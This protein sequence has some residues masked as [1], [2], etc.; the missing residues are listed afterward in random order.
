MRVAAARVSDDESAATA[1]VVRSPRSLRTLPEQIADQ[2]YAGIVAGQ[3]QPG[4]RIREET[5][6]TDLGVSRGPVREAIRILERDAVVRV[7]PNKGAHVTKL[8]AKELNDI[9]EIRIVLAGAMIRRL[10]DASPAVIASLGEK[11]AALERLA[12]RTGKVTEYAS[13]SVDLIL[14]MAQAAGNVQ[15]AEILRSLARQSSR[16][17]QIV[18]SEPARRKLSARKWR[19]LFEALS[20]GRAEEAGRVMEQ[21][22][23]ELRIEAVRRLSDEHASA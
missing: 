11:V 23:D 20:H 5:L 22:V 7:L 1:A 21:M 18:L 14:S 3:Y 9:F 12:N 16:Y 8:S 6:A 10:A 15:L 17:T 4:D 2:I 13:A 19:T